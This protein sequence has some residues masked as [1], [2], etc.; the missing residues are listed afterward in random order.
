MTFI[1]ES[2]D[3]RRLECVALNC[4]DNTAETTQ[5]S[6]RENDY[7]HNTRAAQPFGYS[8][9]SSQRQQPSIHHAHSPLSFRPRR[10]GQACRFPSAADQ[11][12]NINSAQSGAPDLPHDPIPEP[13][14]SINPISI[15]KKTTSGEQQHIQG[16]SSLRNRSRSL[17]S[18]C[19]TQAG[20]SHG[21][22]ASSRHRSR[23]PALAAQSLSYRDR[24]RACRQ[25]SSAFDRS[26]EGEPAPVPAAVHGL[27]IDGSIIAERQ[28]RMVELQKEKNKHAVCVHCW[29]KEL[30]CDQQSPC[31]EC[32][33]RGISC[34]YVACPMA[35][36]A[37]DIKCPAYHQN[38]KFPEGPR[39][40]GCPMHMLALLN[41]HRPFINSYDVEKIQKKIEAPTSAQQIYL[42]LQ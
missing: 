31:K 18:N 28:L 6:P 29:L 4:I 36:C 38:K 3:E 16:L 30:P 13:A 17:N 24:S 5:P 11:A 20:S 21:R 22:P 14:L 2:P 35:N 19:T 39:K 27:N 8:V 41:L 7:N 1:R 15:T 32:K 40:I 33:T 26:D 37:L 25:G 9:Q 42:H 10:L 34:A 12:H 23:S